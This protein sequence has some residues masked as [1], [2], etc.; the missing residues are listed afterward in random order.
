MIFSNITRNKT[1]IQKK[2]SIACLYAGSKQLENGIKKTTQFTGA[3]TRAKHLRQQKG[4][5]QAGIKYLQIAYLLKDL[6]SEYIKY[7]YNSKTTKPQ[8]KNQPTI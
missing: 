2:K 8:F 3:S 5:L 4:K 7:S 1:N 6:Y